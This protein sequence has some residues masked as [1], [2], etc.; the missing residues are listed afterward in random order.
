MFLGY[1]ATVRLRIEDPLH[2]CNMIW[3]EL[4]LT[5]PR[6]QSLIYIRDDRHSRPTRVRIALRGGNI[7]HLFEA[8]RTDES[9]LRDTPKCIVITTY[10]AI[11]SKTWYEK[12]GTFTPRGLRCTG[13]FVAFLASSWRDLCVSIGR[14]PALP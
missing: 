2:G 11:S 14:R 7:N 4:R 6:V 13:H 9:R 10:I 3:H 12:L 5:D 1:L 8:S